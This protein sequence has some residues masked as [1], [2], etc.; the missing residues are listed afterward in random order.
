MDIAPPNQHPA[1][2]DDELAKV[3]AGIGADDSPN[4]PAATSGSN[5]EAAGLQFEETPGPMPAGQANVN[6]PA[7]APSAPAEPVAA[8]VTP[9]PVPAPEPAGPTMPA[10]MAAPSL[11][12]AAG[13]LDELKKT[14]L[15]ELRPLVGKLNLPPEDKF[16]TLL[17]II[18]STD[19]QT[20]LEP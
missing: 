1:T 9:A 11:P 19:D 10:P 2:S 14:A 5:A 12:V 20:L 6:A 18:R 7:P 17:L 13:G 15:E 3:L 8:P 16:D 4:P